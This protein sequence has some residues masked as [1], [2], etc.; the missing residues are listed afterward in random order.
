MLKLADESPSTRSRPHVV[1]FA[2]DSGDGIQ[3]VGFEFAKSTSRTQ[4]DFMTFPDFPAEIRAP[5]GSLFGVSAYQIQFGWDEV[6]TPGDDVDVLVAFN[7][8]ALKTNLNTLKR[9]GLLIVDEQAFDARGLKKAKLDANPLEDGTVADYRLIPIEITKRTLEALAPLELGRKQAVRAKNFWVLGLVY[10]LFERKLAPTEG[11]LKKKF[12]A[13]PEVAEANVAALRAGHAYGETLEIAAFERPA[14]AP[15][16][17]NRH[18]MISGTE[19]MARGIAAVSMLA[20][21]DVLYCSYPITP[22]S[23]LLHSL[24]RIGG[25]VQTFQAEDE[26]AAASA[27]IGASYAGSL[28]VT[29]SSGPGLALK[30]EAL[31]L[32]V[33]AELPL[34]VIDVQRAGPSTGMPTKP[35]QSDLTMAIHGRHGEAPCPVLAPATP[36]DCFSV[37]IDAA[38]MAVSAMTPV[39]VLSDAYLANAASD[40]EAPDVGALPD[41]TQSPAGIETPFAPFA[42]NPE[43]LAR[44]WVPPGTS[45]L[46]HRIGGLEKQDGSGDISY[47][48]A[49]HEEMVRLRTEKIA[50]IADRQPQIEI[51]TGVET[52]DLLV[53]GWGSTYGAIKRAVRELNADGHR[54]GHVHIRQLWPL[55]RG[56]AEAFD[57]FERVLTAEM[58]T[59]QLASILRSELVRPVDCIS[60]VTGQPFRVADLK[61]RLLDRL[62]TN[63]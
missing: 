52:G 41:L 14:D 48:P 8:A 45:G 51:E 25:G 27:A 40:W 29:A 60:H 43:T 59:G 37:M 12:A 21:R 20:G 23:A 24:A 2:G 53:V 46:A 22:A 4:A 38:E 28:G 11:Q 26:I 3:L 58:N 62:E 15:P 7:P 6:L 10:W 13:T 16:A 9:G 19:A 54:V 36:S 18:R 56:L 17:A 32:A 49:N 57:R 35:E 50:R 42:R 34:V 63:A 31:G 55:Q 5:A 44:P 1:R 61:S 30:T 39:I 33:A 47:D